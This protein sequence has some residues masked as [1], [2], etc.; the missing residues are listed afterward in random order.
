MT[1]RSGKFAYGTCDNLFGCADKLFSSPLYLTTLV[2]VCSIS[3]AF[4]AYA[5]GFWLCAVAMSISLV[6]TRNIMP[7]FAAFIFCTISVIEQYAITYE[8]IF[9]YAGVLAIVIPALIFHI[10]KYAPGRRGYTPCKMFAPQLAVSC[11]LLLGG[12][13]SIGLKEYFSLPS[14]Y[15]MLFLGFVLLAIMVFCDCDMPADRRYVSEYIARTLMAAALLFCIMWVIAFIRDGAED[16]PYRQWKN[17]AGNFMLIAMPLTVWKAARSKFGVLYLC[18]AIVQITSVILSGSRGATLCIVA[19]FLPTAVLYLRAIRGQKARFYAELALAA[20]GCVVLA[21]VFLTNGAARLVNLVGDMDILDGNGREELYLLGLKNMLDKPLFGVGIGYINEQAW[22]L[23]DMAIFW[24]HSTP[25]QVAASMGAAGGI[26]YLWQFLARIRL[27][28]HKN[29]YSLTI[30]LSFLGFAGYSCINTGDFTPLPFGVLI[31][32]L[33]LSLERYNY[34][35][36]ALFK[37]GRNF[38]RGK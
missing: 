18:F 28:L 4:S 2:A 37:S 35:L 22:Q 23:N 20:A 29:H 38:M 31:V 30:L 19:T 8:G 26:A 14:I 27:A 12:A 3:Y 13:G 10:I 36:P 17:N 7:A 16:F 33:M 11:A 24:Y 6:C 34:D 9:G 25:V 1:K 5:A 21:S 32:M 15:Y